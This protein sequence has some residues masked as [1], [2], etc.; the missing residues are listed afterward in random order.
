MFNFVYFGNIFYMTKKEYILSLSNLIINRV[1][2]HAPKLQDEV[3]M[4][5]LDAYG[6]D[7]SYPIFVFNRKLDNIYYP[8]FL[9]AKK[10]V[11]FNL[12]LTEIPV[13]SNKKIKNLDKTY[14]IMKEDMGSLLS[15]TIENLNINYL[16]HSNFK[17]ELKEEFLSINGQKINFDY[18]AYYYNKKLMF[19][20]VIANANCYLLNGK[21]YNLT[22]TNTRNEVVKINFQFN[23]PLPRGYYFF[24][25]FNKY[26]EI[27]N[28]TNKSKAYFNYNFNHAN[29]SFSTISGLERCTFP[30]INLQS[31]ISLLPKEKKD[32]YFNF[33]ENKYCLNNPKEMQIFFD[34]SQRK[35]NK[36]FDIKIS[37]K[38]AN[39]DNEFNYLIPR[40]IWESW[41]KFEI[42]EESENKYIKF[43]N[44]IINSSDKGVQISK[45]FAGLKQVSFYRD[46]IWKKVFIIHNHYDYLFADKIKYYNFNLIT[47]EIFKKNNEIY[48]S[49]A[50]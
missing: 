48:L 9:L 36:I 28:L 4:A 43:K 2:F 31:N 34:L 30:C 13:V 21:N 15:S 8:A 40:K 26:I 23:L 44:Q 5:L 22:F 7:A 27:E 35:M 42:D 45:S 14:L 37:S 1:K 6:I 39:L 11:E 32:I 38:N 41:N 24:R 17:K 25:N 33:G 18:H 49:F 46:N 29:I 20:G 10:Q 16:S 19:N 47:K 3:D 12:I 50:D